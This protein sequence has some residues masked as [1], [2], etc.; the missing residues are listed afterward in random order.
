MRIASQFHR[1]TALHGG[2]CD[3]LLAYHP[4]TAGN[5]HVYVHERTCIDPPRRRGVK[6][7]NNGPNGLTSHFIP[8]TRDSPNCRV[9][10]TRVSPDV[11][12]GGRFPAR[13]SDYNVF[14]ASDRAESTAC[15]PSLVDHTT[16][17][18]SWEG[19]LDLPHSDRT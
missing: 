16:S 11:R 15:R 7:R 3:L 13:N 6:K 14:F 18:S 5:P 12:A 4:V 10:S 9:L 8:R 19:Y 2:S 17:T 1:L